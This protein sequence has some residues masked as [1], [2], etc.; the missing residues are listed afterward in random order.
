[1]RDKVGALKAGG[2]SE[3]EAVAKKPT[4]D[5]DAVWGN[6]FMNGG[7]FAGIVYRTL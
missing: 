2:A 7:D 4:A 5:F 1:V 3:L 6:G